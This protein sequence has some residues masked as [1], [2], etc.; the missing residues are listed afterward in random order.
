MNKKYDVLLCGYYGF[1][2][3]GDELL[4]RS[5]TELL[6]SSGIPIDRI[7]VL[8]A[9]PDA[10]RDALGTDAYDRWNFASVLSALRRSKTLLFGG[11]GLFQD[12]TSIRSCVYYWAIA[13]LALICSARPWMVGQ[14]FGPLNGR[15]A[16]FMAK[17]A[18]S[19]CCF[20][21]VR[22]ANSFKMLRS[23]GL[24]SELSPDYV[25]VLKIPDNG[26]R[27][28]KLLLNIRPGYG[29]ISDEL[30]ASSASYAED[31]GREIIYAAMSDDDAR[32]FEELMAVGKLK[33]GPVCLVRKSSDFIKLSDEAAYAVGMRLHFLLLSRLAGLRVCAGAY[34]PKVEAL[35]A[36]LSVPEISNGLSFSDRALSGMRE[37]LAGKVSA[38]FD[39]GLKKALEV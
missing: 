34:D 26:A 22:D 6:S 17:D 24:D 7:A 18:A 28:S 36:E 8:S 38:S 11:G 32:F 4:L 29:K 5:I 25:S 37:E 20:R 21:G 19:C 31:R 15:A 16:K 3:L 14:S 23:W 39:K 33:K 9:S 1:G 30:I 2:N 13:R 12:A 27:G 35:C 10:T